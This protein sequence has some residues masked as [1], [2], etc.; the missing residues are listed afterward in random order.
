MI[1]VSIIIPNYNRAIYI[2]SSIQSVINQTYTNW[3]LIIVDDCS[4]DNSIDIIK[5]CIKNDKRI[6][7]YQMPQNNGLPAVP[8]NFGI[9]KASGDFIAFLDSDDIWLSDKLQ[10]QINLAQQKDAAVVYSYYEKIDSNGFRNNRIV[11]T[12]SKINYKQLLKGNVIG[13]LTGMY[14]VNKLGKIY[15]LYEKVEDY[16]LWLSILKKGHI[17]YA[18]PKVLALYRVGQT[19]FS[20]NKLKA[21]KWTWAVYRKHEHLSIIESIFYFLLYIICGFRKYKI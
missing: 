18:V 2:E 17:A 21:A 9:E 10:E 7:L 19:S 12:P 20:S 11:R 15:F 5:E 1:L 16:I 8:R 14:S 4:T 13:C 3:E 6:K